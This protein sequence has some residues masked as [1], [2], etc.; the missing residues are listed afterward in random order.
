MPANRW[1]SDILTSLRGRLFGIDAFGFMVGAAGY[2][3]PNES[4]S[5]AST[6]EGLGTTVLTGSTATFTIQAPVRAGVLKEII[7]ASSVSTA[8]M[9]VVRSTAAGACSFLPASSGTT[10]SATDA[11]VK[12]INL[13]RSG[14]FVQL[15]AVSTSQWAPIA[16][17]SSEFFTMSTSS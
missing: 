9:A 5:A 4:L 7:N 13:V 16:F 3:E 1:G 2:R 8:A 14:S 6:M 12:R 17:A 11:N 15:R 10:D